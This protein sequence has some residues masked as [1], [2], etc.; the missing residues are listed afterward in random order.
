MRKSTKKELVN[1]LLDAVFATVK[2]SD[3][4]ER[5]VSVALLKKNIPSLKT[6]NKLQSLVNNVQIDANYLRQSKWELAAHSQLMSTVS[7]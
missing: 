2:H 4:V 6:I 1:K 3:P 7:T 5:E